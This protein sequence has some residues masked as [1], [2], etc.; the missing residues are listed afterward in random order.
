M[1]RIS[2][3]YLDYQEFVEG[4][5]WCDRLAKKEIDF[6]VVYCGEAL[7]RVIFSSYD[8]FRRFC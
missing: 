1:Q 4:A 5:A 2:F 7:N 6:S 3:L 8:M